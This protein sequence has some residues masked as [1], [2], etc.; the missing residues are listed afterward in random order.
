MKFRNVVVQQMIATI[1]SKFWGHFDPRL[2][3]YALIFL[4]Y[5]NS[6]KLSLCISNYF[7][8]DQGIGR[9]PKAILKHRNSFEN[10]W[11]Q[12]DPRL[13]DEG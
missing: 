7:A 12:I 8:R 11:G 9:P 10:D 3:K 2:Q 5:E 6:P 1:H 4:K 13:Q